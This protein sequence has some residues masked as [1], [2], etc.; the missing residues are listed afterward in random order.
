MMI[1]VIATTDQLRAKT[2]LNIIK[3]TTNAGKV[4]KE[5]RMRFHEVELRYKRQQQRKSNETHHAVKLTRKL[6][7]LTKQL[8]TH[9]MRIKLGSTSKVPTHLFSGLFKKIGFDLKPIDMN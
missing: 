5:Q 3:I 1:K 2:Q 7:L 8:Y 9:I 6:K 4:E